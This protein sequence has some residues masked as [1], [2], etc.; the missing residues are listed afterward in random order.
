M[1]LKILTSTYEVWD[2]NIFVSLTGF[3]PRVPSKG[4][5]ISLLPWSLPSSHTAKHQT[6]FSCSTW[7]LSTDC[8]NSARFWATQL[9]H[10]YLTGMAIFP[11]NLKCKLLIICPSLSLAWL[12]CP[13][14]DDTE[15]SSANGTLEWLR[16]VGH[17]VPMSPFR[18]EHRLALCS[19][20]TIRPSSCQCSEWRNMQDTLLLAGGVWFFTYLSPAPRQFFSLTMLLLSTSLTESSNLHGSIEFWI[21]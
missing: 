13:A 9:C 11:G 14:V 1:P 19:P 17:N 20:L 10:A 5:S 6:D 7:D 18:R 2:G 12:L 15:F 3:R 4:L 8:L 21:D 16:Y